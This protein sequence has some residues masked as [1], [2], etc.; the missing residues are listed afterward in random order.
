MERYSIKKGFFDTQ[1]K[2]KTKGHTKGRHYTVDGD[3]AVYPATKR[4]VDP[5]RLKFLQ[6]EGFVGTE[7]IEEE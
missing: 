3:F 1:D 7:P 2:L 4:E 5:D 6:D